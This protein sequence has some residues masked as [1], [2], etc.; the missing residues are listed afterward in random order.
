MKNTLAATL[1]FNKVY[2]ENKNTVSRY[3]SNKI[4]NKEIAEELVEDVFIKVSQHLERFDGSISALSTWIYN[5]AK[6][7]LID[8]FRKTLNAEGLPKYNTISID[9]NEGE[10][11]SKGH[12]EI[13]ASDSSPLQQMI[14]NETTS[15]VKDAIKGLTKLEKKLITLYAIKSK[16]YEEIAEELDMP[17]GTV[18]GTIHRARLSLKETLQPAYAFA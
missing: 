10:E 12:V 9:I 3:I 13:A 15:R 11:T 1:Q 14:T 5:I 16:T 6:N 18:K 17:M 8:H 2:R 7:T 4:R